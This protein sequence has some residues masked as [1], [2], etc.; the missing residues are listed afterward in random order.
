M[1]FLKRIASRVIGVI[2]AIIVFIPC[3][4]IIFIRKLR[5]SAGLPKKSS[6]EPLP[7]AEKGNN[8]SLIIH[9]FSPF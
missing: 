6:P 9:D 1:F 7:P 8:N 2:L 3:I 5:S 4:I